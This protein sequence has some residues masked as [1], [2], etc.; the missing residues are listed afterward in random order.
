[1]NTVLVKPV[2]ADCNLSCTYCFYH[3]RPT[4]P[5][6]G[7]SKHRMSDEVLASFIQQFMAL[8]DSVSFCW[9]GGEPMLA[10]L[11][12]YERM[13][14]YQKKYGF[15]GQIVSNSLQTNGVLVDSGWA[16]F[17]RQ[18]NV[19]VGTSLDGPG[20]I[21]DKYRQYPAGK[22]SFAKVEQAIDILREYSV[23]FNILSVVSQANVR[24]ARE[25]FNFF[26]SQGLP[27]LQFIPCA[28]VEES[29]KKLT[30]FA[31]NPQEYEAFLKELF[32]VW[33][34][35]CW[36]ETPL[37]GRGESRARVSIRFFDNIL[38]AYVGRGAESCEFKKECGE[39]IVVEYN[40]DVYPCDFLVEREFYLGNL[41]ERP[42]ADIIESEK[43]NTFKRL[44]S[45]DYP[46][47]RSCR[48][49]FICNQGCTRLRLTADKVSQSGHLYCSA[50][51][52]FFSYS[53][54]RFKSLAEKVRVGI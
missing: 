12:F 7:I 24:K 32:E 8:D 34:D 18:Y 25:V 16:G 2:S 3:Q 29:E 5:Y 15:P 4:D 6:A 47:C 44:K 41:L 37:G 30:P 13:V 43:F 27:Y 39:Y 38:S 33:F 14:S 51:R 22:G 48:Y 31:I 11:D 1:M 28:E 49:K 20:E 54:D 35:A 21:H 46:E 36:S 26:L 53:E 45:K 52:N 9:Q 10:G 40:G 50:Y 42:L 17:F 23:E 19:F